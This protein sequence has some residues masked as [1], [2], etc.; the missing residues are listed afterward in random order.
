[1]EVTQGQ[2]KSSCS[3]GHHLIAYYPCTDDIISFS[4]R[5]VLITDE[6]TYL[7]SIDD[8]LETF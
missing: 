4:L 8:F 6:K 2:R 5:K 1:V 7:F 3:A